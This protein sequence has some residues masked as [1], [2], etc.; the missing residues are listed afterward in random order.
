M[1]PTHHNPHFPTVDKSGL[2]LESSCALDDAESDDDDIG[3]G[4]DK[5]PD[6]PTS[7]ATA[8]MTLLSSAHGRARRELRSISK[9]DL[10]AAVKHGKKEPNYIDRRTGEQRWK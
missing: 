6:V 1:H 8:E 3:T 9:H 5:E 2:P 4:I 10:Q 7:R